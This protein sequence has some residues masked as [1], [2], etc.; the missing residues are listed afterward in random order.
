MSARIAPTYTRPNA[1]VCRSLKERTPSTSSNT[2]NSP[3]FQCATFGPDMTSPPSAWTAKPPT[4]GRSETT[5][6]MAALGSRRWT[7]APNASVNQSAP[8]ASVRGPST[9]L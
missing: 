6:S 3:S 4:I 7:V 8:S 1:S 9:S 2:R 5:V